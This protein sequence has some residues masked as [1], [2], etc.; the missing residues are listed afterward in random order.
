MAGPT[1]LRF[2]VNQG[3][4]VTHMRG[5]NTSLRLLYPRFYAVFNPARI[6]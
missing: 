4:S 6:K 5:S 1:E 2:V 3:Q